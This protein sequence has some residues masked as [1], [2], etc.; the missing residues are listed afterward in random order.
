[1]MANRSCTVIEADLQFVSMSIRGG[2]SNPKPANKRMHGRCLYLSAEIRCMGPDWEV[3]RVLIPSKLLPR[4]PCYSDSAA[5]GSVA[6]APRTRSHP[7]PLP[8]GAC[9]TKQRRSAGGE[10]EVDGH[11]VAD[12]IARNSRTG[13]AD[14]QL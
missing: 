14:R 3:V 10:E 12:L 8:A 9:G 11:G 7:S 5:G 4:G 1:M 6:R 13:A 2:R